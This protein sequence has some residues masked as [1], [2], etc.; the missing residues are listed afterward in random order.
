MSEPRKTIRRAVPPT[1]TPREAI[2]DRVSNIVIAK[3]KRARPTYDTRA[4]LRKL[5]YAVAFVAVLATGFG[6]WRWVVN[7]PAPTTSQYC[8]AIPAGTPTSDAVQI[9]QWQR[10]HC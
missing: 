7:I 9:R 1:R 4:E 3:T 6:A 8:L 5:A 2:D 10:E